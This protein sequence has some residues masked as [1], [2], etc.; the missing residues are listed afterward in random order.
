MKLA[1][2]SC[3]SEFVTFAFRELAW[4]CQH[5]GT[6]ILP[7]FRGMMWM[8]PSAP[9]TDT[10]LDRFERAIIDSNQRRRGSIRAHLRSSY[11]D[12]FFLDDDVGFLAGGDD[13]DC[14]LYLDFS[15]RETMLITKSW[16]TIRSSHVWATQSLVLCEPQ[17]DVAQ[18]MV[19]V[20]KSSVETEIW[21][22]RYAVA[23][24]WVPRYTRLSIIFRRKCRELNQREMVN[25]R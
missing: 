21:W 3:G 9:N 23:S 18:A 1:V 10:P 7:N 4:K 22:R 14:I 24:P 2:A 15:K 13:S 19:V 25:R 6:F 11:P 16:A 12:E 5:F 17:S 20:S 8:K